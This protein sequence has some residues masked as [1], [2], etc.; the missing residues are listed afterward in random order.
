MEEQLLLR[1]L[2]LRYLPEVKY[3]PANILD[4][5]EI[6]NYALE[7]QPSPVRV[8]KP[9]LDGLALP[10]DDAHCACEM[11]NIAGLNKT[12]QIPPTDNFGANGKHG[13]Y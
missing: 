7:V 11:W 3:Q 1:F 2:P 8:V 9:K 13:L 5:Q 6:P 4:L 10:L 12:T